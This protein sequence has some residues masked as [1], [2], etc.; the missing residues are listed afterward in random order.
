MEESLVVEHVY[1]S[2]VIYVAGKETLVDL[3]VLDMTNFDVILG[4]DWLAFFHASLDCFSKIVKISFSGEPSCII[5]GDHSEVPNKLIL[6][7]C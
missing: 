4:M 3:K 7:G 6:I 5:Q 2:C 1:Q